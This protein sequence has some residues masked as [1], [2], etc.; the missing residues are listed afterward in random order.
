[1][2]TRLDPDDP[3]VR[4]RRREDVRRGRHGAIER[5]GFALDDDRVKAGPVFA[6]GANSDGN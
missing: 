4:Q 6:L 3:E 2:T 1:V 5:L